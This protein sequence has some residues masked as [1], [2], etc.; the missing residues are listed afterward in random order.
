MRPIATDGVA[1]PC[2]SVCPSRLSD[3][4][5]CKSGSTDRDA[6]RDVDTGGPNEPRIDGVQITTREGAILMAKRGRLRTC[7]D[8]S[9]VP[10]TPSDSEGGR[11]G[12]VPIRMYINYFVI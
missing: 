12:T 1:R 2:L 6:V 7:P 10:Y 8:M 9:Y 5:A 3:C 4:K 11:T